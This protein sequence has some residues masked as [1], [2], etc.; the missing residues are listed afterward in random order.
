MISSS[1]FT[2]KRVSIRFFEA[3]F[4]V[5]LLFVFMAGC[6]SGS[7][8]PIAITLS[9]GAT[10]ALDQG[11]TV[12][13][14][15]TV[16]HDKT[17]AGVGW[18]LTSGPGAL[19]N[20][21]TTGATYSANGATGTA[22]ITAT[23][24]T[25][26]TATATLTI[27]VTAMP[28]ITTT[29]LPAVTEGATYS[30][31][32]AKTGGAGTSTFTVSTGTLPAGLT[33]SSSGTISGTPTGPNGTVNFTIK[34]TDASTVAPQSATQALSIVINMPAPPAITTTT[35]PGGTEGAAYSQQIAATG[36]APLTFS[37]STGTVPAGLTLS[38]AGL[39]SGTPTGPNG[40]S[41]FT[42][43]VLDSSNPVQSATQA[44][45]IVIALPPAPV[46]STTTLPAGTEGSAYSQQIAATGHGTLTFTTSA[47]T[48]PTGLT[49]SAS[50]LI[51]GTPTGPN[52]T[53][54][55]T[56]K[57]TDSSNPTQSST[58]ALSIVINLPAPPSITTTSL[59]AGV[60]GTAYNQTIQA[61]GGSGAL[62]FSI[63]VGSLPAGLTMSSTGVITGT[64]P[65]PNGT[66][67]FTVQVAD[68]S[69][70][71]QT[72]TKALSILINLPT[73]PSIAP[74]TLPGGTLGT[75]YTATLTVSNG[76]SPYSWSV[77][78][79]SLPAGLGL[80]SNGTTATISGT[81]TT[82]QSNVAFTIQV[83]DSSKPNQDGTQAYT[84]SIA[85]AQALAITSTSSQIPNATI[86][87]VYTTSAPL[88][89]LTAS[90][91]V[92]PYIWD[93][94]P[95]T[96]TLPDGLTLN[97]SGQ[98]I[99]TV[100][101][102]AVTES[103]TVKV[104]DSATPADSATSGSL[105]I[106]VVAAGTHNSYLSGR[107]VCLAE[108]FK[109]SD[110]SRWAD[111]SSIVADGKGNISSGT[112]DTNATDFTAGALTGTLT[113]TYTVGTNNLGTLTTV[114]GTATNQ[115]GIALSNFAGPV[116]QQFRRVEINDAGSSPSGQHGTGNCYLATTSAFSST[117]LNGNSFV[118]NFRGEDSSKTPSASVG[119]LSASNGSYSNC[120]IDYADGSGTV[121]SDGCTGTYTAPDST[122]GRLTASFTPTGS[123]TRNWVVYII[124]A[125]RAFMLNTTTS[126]GTEAGELRK[127]QQSS[128][129]NSNFKG[130]FVLYSQGFDFTGGS[131]SGYY[132]QVF[133]G[134]GDGAGS[135]TINE[136]YSNDSGTFKSGNSNGTVTVTFDSS[137]PG[138]ATIATGGGTVYFYFYGNNLAAEMSAG[139]AEW[140]WI[141]AQTQ[142]TF[143][144]AAEAGSYMFGKLPLMEE[145]A[146]GNAGVVTLDGSGNVSGY[147][148]TAGAGNVSLDQPT[149]SSYAWS[150]TVYG[151]VTVT[152]V[153]NG[154]ATCIVI[155]P[156]EFACL[157]DTGGKPAIGIFQQ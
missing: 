98:I 150:S 78:A 59:P 54:N 31:V 4:L 48:L 79:G 57:V 49:M 41:N 146:N 66:A 65:G 88:A 62:T 15:A 126:D 116:A 46:I 56:V 64:P 47:G 8:K 17:S 25:D 115:W 149:S 143:T 1:R 76:L 87:A 109:D 140:G 53:S 157:N 154:N 119:R 67:S 29:S 118:W 120:Y 2:A 70:P 145:A 130:P 60:E 106:T 132:A 7:S 75:A 12:N 134:T 63:T 139:S 107:Y 3:A 16:S 51:S 111:V 6:N 5:G 27:T 110:Q 101:A 93:T 69:N 156:T 77:S 28:A 137:H 105:T 13:I 71:V 102:D 39:I 91:G 50:G 142:T 136:S 84:V 38:T 147:N 125:N 112:W 61:T 124:D 133:Q 34:L 21:T 58:Q 108:G 148:T 135:V 144:Y 11:Q 103:F 24:V 89:T 81:P 83:T 23:S 36:L 94:T 73:A 96:G 99:G 40:T 9:T 123:T 122:T 117:T 10:Q 14:S 85:P 19:T 72:A 52:G 26:K 121:E 92:A 127:Q 104:T 113:G 37:T 97:A 45:S 129:S 100:A 90:G 128:Y 80:T 20:P 42:V 152:D 151:V 44:L 138:R 82:V 153:S 33:L 22:V 55:F 86:G 43:K 95:I 74:A 131:V 141:E 155:S 18:T 30:Q 68:H 32:L 114:A 35:L